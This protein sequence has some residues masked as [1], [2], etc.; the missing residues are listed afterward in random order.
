MKEVGW[1]GGRSCVGA[2]DGPLG[3]NARQIDTWS[4]QNNPVAKISL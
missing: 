3:G 1:G 2:A 4:E